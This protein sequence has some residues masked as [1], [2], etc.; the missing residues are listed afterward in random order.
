MAV[1]LTP[2]LTYGG[3]KSFRIYDKVLIIVNTTTGCGFTPQYEGLEE[4]Y[5]KYHD[6]GLEILDFPFNQFGHEAPVNNDEIHQFFEVLSITCKNP[7][8]IKW[9]FTKFLIDKEG[10]VIGRY[11]PTIK[12]EEME[13]KIKELL[14]IN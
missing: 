4:L 13:L 9:N 3:D 2:L 10:K 7:E 14:N 11:S 8:N 5:K 1:N 12:P 6:R